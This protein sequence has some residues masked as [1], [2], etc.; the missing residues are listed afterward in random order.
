MRKQRKR[1]PKSILR[2]KVKG[3]HIRPGRIPVPAL[4][5][6][7]EKA[8]TAIN[9]Q[10][11]VLRGKRGLRRGPTATLVKEECTLELF[12]IGKGSAVMSFA[13]PEA[14]HSRQV[15]LDIDIQRLGESAVRQIVESIQS[16]KKGQPVRIDPGIRRSLQE[17]GELLNNGLTSIEW[18][19]PNLQGGRRTR[20]V[21]DRET[22]ERINES[23]RTAGTKPVEIDGR[24][25][26]ADFKRGDL[27]CLIHTPEG[28]RT[29]CSF[30]TE[31]ED[32][33]YKALRHVARVKGLGT[34]N[35]ETK[36]IEHI[37]LKSVEVLD[38]FLGHADDFVSGLTIEQ[39]TK[40]QGVDPKLDLRTIEDVWPEK[41]DVD[42]FLL[43]VYK[44]RSQ[45][46]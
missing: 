26:M 43:G 37:E 25:E 1:P 45:F 21:V 3:P 6:L 36:M 18:S 14:Q 28:R 24:L 40:A 30:K 2:L 32:D 11:E 23:V 7:C 19:T 16:I 17:M 15:P 5:V 9:R 39:L 35:P 44:R 4:L 29:P 8:Q 27:K 38:P 34:V 31:L 41:E 20:V 46:A 42:Q 22:Q 33:V 13:G 12:S 10:A